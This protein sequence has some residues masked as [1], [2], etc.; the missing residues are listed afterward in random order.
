MLPISRVACEGMEGKTELGTCFN[1]GGLV[2]KGMEGGDGRWR[3]SGCNVSVIMGGEI[4][5]E[6]LI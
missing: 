3:V 6:D 5:E 4:W 2:G 1:G